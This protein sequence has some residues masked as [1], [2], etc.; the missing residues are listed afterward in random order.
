[1]T[2]LYFLLGLLFIVVVFGP[3]LMQILK[4][5]W[6]VR[7]NDSVTTFTGLYRRYSVG[8]ATGYASHIR[9]WENS[10]E[11]GSV[12][13][14]TSATTTGYGVSATT[15]IHDNRQKL[16]AYHLGFVLT[17]RNGASSEI[18][19]VNVGASIQ[20]G[21]LISAAWLIHKGKIG[22]AFVVY[23][24]S[25]D[26][27]YVEQVRRRLDTARRGIGKMIFGLP[28][29][30][31]VILGVL[32]VTIPLLVILGLA[33]MYH[34]RRFTTRGVQPLVA[35]L[36]SR[37]AEYPALRLESAK[38]SDAKSLG[39]LASQMKEIAALH[40]SGTLSAEEFQAAKSK[41]LGS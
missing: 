20:Q 1:M 28:L 17:D 14:Q 26:K 40:E 30:Y 9:S 32:I 25:T 36:A 39:D 10:R 23:N 34:V 11:F 15:T 38:V 6:P 8:S 29:A 37:A 7:L 41:L 12:T 35:S 13:A 16:T 5:F 31:V 3:I 18:E 19:A 27:V 2:A 33:S 21:D 24:H 22:N 4:A